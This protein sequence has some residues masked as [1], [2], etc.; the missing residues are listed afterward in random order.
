MC[1][2]KIERD[3]QHSTIVENLKAGLART[4]NEIPFI[5]SVIVPDDEERETYKPHF[6][7]EATGVWC[8]EQDGLECSFDKME[9]RGISL[10]C[11]PNT[12]FVP[13]PRGHSEKCPIFTVLATFIKSGL[14]VTY[15]EHHGIMDAQSLGTS[16]SVWSWN[17][18]AVSEGYTIPMSE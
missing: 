9:K 18:L 13:D 3:D 2:F 5:A 10:S 17:V 6:D 4:I 14:V 12:N 16:V 7:E 8:H 15:N 11:F 1:A